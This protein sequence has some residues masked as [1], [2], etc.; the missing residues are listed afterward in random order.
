YASLAAVYRWT[1]TLLI[2]WF[3]SLMLRPYGLESLGRMLCVFAIAGMV[4]SLFQIPM[5]F[6]KN[7]AR[8]TKV[9]WTRLLRFVCVCSILIGATMWPMPSSISTTARFTPRKQTPVYISTPG[10]LE[11]LD[12]FPGDTIAT[13]VNHDVQYEYAKA[14]GR[15]QI[16]AQLVQS[17]R[18]RRYQSPETGD[19]LPAAEALLADLN[20]Q[21]E[22]RRERRDALVI[23]ASASGRLIA[24]SR[25]PAATSYGNDDVFQL[26]G[27]S[28][29]PTDPENSEGYFQSGTELMSIVEGEDWD[30]EIVMSQSEVQRIAFGSKV[31]IALLSDPAEVF[32]G[33]V[34]DISRSQWTP[35]LNTP[36][37]DDVNATRQQAPA[38]TS[39]VVRAAVKLPDPIHFRAGSSVISRIEAAPIS[40]AGR[41]IRSLNGLLRFR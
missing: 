10:I 4:Y 22:T 3:V 20:E 5:R 7:P 16:Q 36:R 29:Y 35:E 17:L 13:L 41:I 9:Q 28:G 24:G 8:R 21:L 37:W 12:A 27:W 40:L 33:I 15:V 25:R 19:E 1:L 39:Y 23:R 32:N 11:R 38:T 14:Q 31:K 30:I 2:L 34:T 26:V 18:Q 6:L